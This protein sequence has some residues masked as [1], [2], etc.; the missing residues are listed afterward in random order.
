MPVIS[1][2]I[3]PEVEIST[4]E[5]DDMKII[6]IELICFF[7]LNFNVGLSSGIWGK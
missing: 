3:F 1:A 7:H 5:T 2:D 4:Q 6:I